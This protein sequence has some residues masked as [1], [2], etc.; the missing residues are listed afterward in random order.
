MRWGE[1]GLLYTT[2][3]RLILVIDPETLLEKQLVG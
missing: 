2:L 3:G 1:D